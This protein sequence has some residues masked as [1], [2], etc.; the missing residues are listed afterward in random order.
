MGDEVLFFSIKDPAK[1]LKF[2]VKKIF[3]DPQWLCLG[4]QALA[5]T[6]CI[7]VEGED[8]YLSV[9]DRGGRENV[10]CILGNFNTPNLLASIRK[11]A[12]GKKFYLCFDCDPAGDKYAQK[13]GDTIVAGG[14][15][16][17]VIKIPES[18]GD[19]DD[20]LRA[21]KDPKDDFDKLLEKAA[22]FEKS[23]PIDK[24]SGSLGESNPYQFT[25]FDVIGETEAGELV[26]WSHCHSK[27]YITTLKDLSIDKLC[28]VGGFEVQQRVASRNAGA[29][30]VLF[31]T[32]KKSLIVEAG[33]RQLGPLDFYARGFIAWGMDRCYW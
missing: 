14:G 16:V 8:D 19:I 13:Y 7:L 29:G 1:K 20:F 5:A 6:E 17:R 12:K 31:R 18:H 11:D 28:Q 32:L 25:S 22:A 3:A 10:V 9:I 30:Q 27:L 15:E 2:Q 26:F 4:Q 24:A 33:R 21:S 23:Q